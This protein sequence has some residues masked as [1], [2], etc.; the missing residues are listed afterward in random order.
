MLELLELYWTY[1]KISFVSF[2][3]M[4]MVPLLQQEMLS[5]GWM[6]E[7]EVGDIVAI[8]EMT[9]GPLSLNCASFVG[10]RIAGI[11][12]S[13]FANLGVMTPSLTVAFL[14][15][16]FLQKFQKSKTLSR[17][18]YGVRPAALGMIIA[19]IL[20]LS[21][22]NY[23]ISGSVYFPT[24]IIGVIALVLLMVAK[25]NIPLTILV[26]AAMGILITR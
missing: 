16:I 23:F 26:S 12:G 24:V 18:M 21:R 4:S 20:T 15:V 5:H 7:A 22:E 11:R 8:A 13:L 1:V 19:T 10:M 9:P 25:L 14:A 3:G 2:G 17:A 6:T